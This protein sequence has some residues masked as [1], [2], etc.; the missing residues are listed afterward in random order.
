MT[1]NIIT[2]RHLVGST[3]I[4]RSLYRTRNP[5]NGRQAASTFSGKYPKPPFKRQSQPWPGLARKMDP[6]PDHGEASYKG[7]GRLA[8]C[9]EAGPASWS[10]LSVSNQR[11]TSSPL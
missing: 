3:G 2:R 4:G 6:R 8:G 5:D 11:F 7:S 1:A 10:D 9:A